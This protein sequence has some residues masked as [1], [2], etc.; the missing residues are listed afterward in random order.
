MPKFNMYQSLHTTVIGPEGKPVEMQIRTHDDAPHAPS[1]ASPR[2]GSTRSRPTAA[3]PPARGRR[4]PQRHGLA[5]PAARLAAR[6]RGPGGVPRL[7]ALRDRQPARSTSSR[8]KGDVDRAAGRARRPVDFAYAV[9]TEVGHRCIGA[10]VNGR[11]VP[12]ESTLDN[13]DVVEIFTSKADGAGPTPRL[14]DASSRARGPATRSGSGSP[15]SAARRRSSTAR[16][17]IAKAMRKQG[18]PLQRLMTGDVAD[19]RSRTS[20]AT[21]TSPRCTP[22]SARA[23]S[24][25]RRVVQRLVA[26]ARRRGGRRPRTS[27]RRRRRPAPRTP[28]A[29][30]ATRASSS[31][32]STDVW[33]KLARCCTPVPGDPIIGFVTRGSGVSVHRADCTNVD[34]AAGQPERLIEVEWAPTAASRV[35]RRRSRSRRSTAPGCSPTSPGCCPTSTSTSCRRRCTTTPRPGGHLAGSPSRWATRRTSATCSGRSA[36]RRRLRRLPGHLGAQAGR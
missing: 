3:P 20:C 21:P 29:A 28:A 27:P 12:L 17:R 25:R 8:P 9:H 4:R 24:R 36:D 15:R 13:G 31:R 19:R 32:A 6:D 5:A 35:P 22:R 23:T 14:A 1:T 18:L 34:V 16:T 10:R 30:P 26:V 11:L 7:A 33:V 2:T